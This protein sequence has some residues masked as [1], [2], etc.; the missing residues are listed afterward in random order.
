MHGG[1]LRTG[2]VMLS[3]FFLGLAASGTSACSSSGDDSDT[4]PTFYCTDANEVIVDEDKCDNDRSGLYFLA[5]APFFVK[6][7]K[8]GTR[9]PSG[10]S[11]FA[12]SDTAARASWGL[13]TTGRISNGTTVKSGVIGTSGSGTGTTS[14]S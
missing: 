11:R 14:G 5:F 2:R 6:G 4:P 9:L 8:P 10:G 1:R 7:L 3:A 13:P 12:A